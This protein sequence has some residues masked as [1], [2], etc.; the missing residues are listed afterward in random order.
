MVKIST[1]FAL[2]ILTAL[3]QFTGFPKSFKDFLYV[4]FGIAIAILSYLIRKELLEVVRHLHD[5]EPKSSTDS[6]QQ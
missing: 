5:I 4:V 2:G 1:I 6:S 3:V